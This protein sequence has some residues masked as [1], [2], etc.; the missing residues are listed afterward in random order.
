[1]LEAQ[2]GVLVSKIAGNKVKTAA[3]KA[4]KRTVATAKKAVRT[5]KAA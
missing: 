5:R 3:K 2:S 4:V 1:K